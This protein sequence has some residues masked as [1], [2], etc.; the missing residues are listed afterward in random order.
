MCQLGAKDCPATKVPSFGFEFYPP[1][2][3]GQKQMEEDKRRWLE[4]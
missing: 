3:E 4:R 2:M 1:T